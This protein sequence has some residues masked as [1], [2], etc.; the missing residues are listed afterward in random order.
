MLD[1][2]RRIKAGRIAL[3]ASRMTSTSWSGRM[4][5][6]AACETCGFCFAPGLGPLVYRP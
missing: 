1:F 6:P 4:T 3:T 2:I 5:R